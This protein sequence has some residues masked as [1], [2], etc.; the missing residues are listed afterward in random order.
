MQKKDILEMEDMY[1]S[2]NDYECVAKTEEEKDT[3]E[4]ENDSGDATPRRKRQK[5]CVRGRSKGWRNPS[6]TPTADPAALATPSAALA[7]PT[8]GPA[9]SATPSAAPATLTAG[10][11]ASAT[12]LLLLP[13]L[14]LAMLPL[15]P[16][17]LPLPPLAILMRTQMALQSLLLLCHLN[18]D[19]K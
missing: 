13:P 11:A 10:P 6:A 5:K 1:D 16:L 3:E 19:A 14:L 15:S 12:L 17:L 18:L 4:F 2:D 9:T 8:A 7:T